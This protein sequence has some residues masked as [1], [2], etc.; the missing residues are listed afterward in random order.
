MENCQTVV[1]AVYVTARGHT[2]SGFRLYL[3]KQWCQD[4]K[5][6][7]QAHVPDEVEFAIKPALGTAMITSAADV[8]VLFAWAAADEVYGRGAKLREAYEKENKG[9]VVAVR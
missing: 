5:R 1:F 8:G 7:E 9:Y 4:S 3:P 6:R 2:L